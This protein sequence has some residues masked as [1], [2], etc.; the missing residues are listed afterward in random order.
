MK[1]TKEQEQ[2][3]EKEFLELQHTWSTHYH[4]DFKKTQSFDMYYKAGR[5]KSMENIPPITEIIISSLVKENYELRTKAPVTYM[6]EIKLLKASLQEKEQ[7]IESIERTLEGYKTRVRLTKLPDQE[8]L[9]E[10]L[11]AN[12]NLYQAA[13]SYEVDNGQERKDYYEKIKTFLEKLK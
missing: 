2:M 4:E 3:I 12:L 5:L 10:A 6:E 1:T 9:K 7:E 8:E 13:C 11:E